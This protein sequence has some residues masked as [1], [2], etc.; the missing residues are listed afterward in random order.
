MTTNRAS[1]Q[2]ISGI[3]DTPPRKPR[4]HITEA[5]DGHTKAPAERTTT[6]TDSVQERSTSAPR[7]QT[8]A[9]T[10]ARTKASEQSSGGVRTVSFR[11]PLPLVEALRKRSRTTGES[12]PNIVLDAI[13]ATADRLPDLVA[14]GGEKDVLFP[15]LES[16]GPKN[17]I[18]VAIRVT[19]AA[20]DA[21]D[22]LVP[23]VNA[24]NR[25]ELIVAALN[26]YLVNGSASS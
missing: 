7:N 1:F 12:Q 23:K 16:R 19:A 11:A 5:R 13:E 4:S 2:S 17:R 20:A 22:A 24:T 25:T 3:L 8:R 26:A 14:P 21:I 15:R 10:H 9:G 6:T 18:P